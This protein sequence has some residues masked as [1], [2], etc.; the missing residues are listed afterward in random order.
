[1]HGNSSARGFWGLLSGEERAALT[2]LSLTR[3]FPPGVTMC[4][5]GDPATH[6][7]VL[8]DGWVKILSVTADGQE[9]VLAL[10]GNGDVVGELA[11]EM[12]GHRTA[13]LQAIDLVHALIV[14]YE[15]FTSFLDANPGAAR[16][17]R[18]EMT[19]RWGDAAD[20]LRRHP[21]TSGAQRLAALLL[22]LAGRHGTVTGGTGDTGGQIDVAMPL[23][24]QELAN[25]A[26]TSRATVA[27]AFKSWRDR[28]FVR[29]GQKHITITNPQRLRQIADQRA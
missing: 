16:A 8:V 25:L 20:L 4:H 2:A 28:G 11:G 21:L 6:L 9:R 29:T 12:S 24:Q 13:T 18:H 22:E 5:E 15:R 19:Q 10:R 23:S 7:Y 3:D 26:G 1:M 17:Y 27:R 14:G